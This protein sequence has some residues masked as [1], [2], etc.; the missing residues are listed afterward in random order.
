[1]KLRIANRQTAALTRVEVLVVIS[2][3]AILAIIV[4]LP[5]YRA[6]GSN[7]KKINCV[8][9][10]KQV[11][12]AF[13]IWA[14]DNSDNF[15]MLVSVR[16]GGAMELATNTWISFVVMSNELTTPKILH[17][18][19]DES[20]FA[21][22]NFQ[23]GFNNEN[24]SYFVGLDANTNSSNILLS[25]DANFSINS[26]PVKSGLLEL[27]TNAL[28]AWTSGRHYLKCNIVMADGSVV[29]GGDPNTPELTNLFSKTGFATNRLA[30]P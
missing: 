22:T 8:N 21:A 25:G 28:I 29:G 26:V 13:R 23:A 5:A 7:A 19:A 18:P 4:V 9:N 20:R 12:L 27:C 14:G 11:G 16:N 30:I 2:I 17:C 15:P 6:A 10:L 24:V 3:L 1:M